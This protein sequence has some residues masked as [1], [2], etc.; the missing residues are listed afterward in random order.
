MFDIDKILFMRNSGKILPDAK[1]ED[2]LFAKKLQAA[3]EKIVTIIGNPLSF[4]A[5]KAQTAKSTKISLSPIQDLHGY[6]NPW[7]DGGGKQKANMIVDNIVVGKYIDNDGVEQSQPNNFY[8]SEPIPVKALTAYTMNVS[9]S[10]WY[11]SFMEY[12]SNNTFIKRTLYGSSSVPTGKTVTITTDAN[13][14]YILFGSNMFKTEPVTLNDILALTWM[15]SEGSTAADYEPYSNICPITGRTSATLNV[16]GKNLFDKTRVTAGYFDR[17]GNISPV[18]NTKVSDFMPVIS[19]KTYYFGEWYTQRVGRYTCYY[20]KN[21]NFISSFTPDYRGEAIT[22]PNNVCFVRTSIRNEFVDTYQLELGSE[23]TTYEPY[24]ESNDITI[25]FGETVYGGTLD[26]ETG[27]LVVDRKLITIGDYSWTH[28]STG[29][30]VFRGDFNDMKDKDESLISSALKT[31]FSSYA[32]MPPYSVR[33]GTGT[34][35]K[36]IVIKPSSDI[37]TQQKLFDVIGNETI[38][39]TLA[40]PITISLTPEEVQLLKGVNNIWTDWDSIELTYKA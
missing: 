29:G 1:I 22:I 33:T 13:T 30:G 37:T 8:Y 4:L 39:Y 7:P 34:S 15:L 6:N 5:K 20:D 38:C 32:S 12:D 14:A 31:D 28:T 40:T 17:D 2:I 16:C 21:K 19:G 27:E 23:A 26:V 3:A 11:M 25:Q 9:D 24:T 35:G 18:Q 36:R 10:V